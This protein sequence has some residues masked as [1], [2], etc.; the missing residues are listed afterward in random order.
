MLQQRIEKSKVKA[1][2]SLVSKADIRDRAKTLLAIEGW[3]EV[4]G[5]LEGEMLGLHSEYLASNSAMKFTRW[6]TR[7]GVD[8]S[9]VSNVGQQMV[10]ASVKFSCGHNDLMRLA[11]TQHYKSCMRVGSPAGGQQLHYLA[12]PDMALIFIPD[13]AGKYKW[14]ALIRLVNDDEGKPALVH[15]KPYGNGP[16]DS[17][18]RF[19]SAK[20][21][22]KVYR[23]VDIK[24]AADSYLD[25]KTFVSPTV[26]NNAM[27][28]HPIWTDH[29]V[30]KS[31]SGRTTI[32]VHP[33]HY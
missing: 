5:G 17:I 8:Q 7:R 15:Y 33:Q 23:A 21:E 19:L 4:V 32:L 30:G 20:S 24:L 27:L 18:F 16:S 2:K 25:A 10:H 11:D 9:E 29:I 26:C 6:L 22:I 28:I 12:D 14:R 1:S 31:N 13:A 3:Y